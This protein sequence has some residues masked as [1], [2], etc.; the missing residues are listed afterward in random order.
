MLY[1]TTLSI[2]FDAAAQQTAFPGAIENFEPFDDTPRQL[3]SW[4]H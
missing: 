2:L 4:Q 1:L 3:S